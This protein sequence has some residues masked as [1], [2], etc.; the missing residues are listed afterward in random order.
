MYEFTFDPE[1]NKKLIKERNISFEEV[2]CLINENKLIDV[3]D[4]HNKQEYPN[5]K[6]YVIDVEGYIY[7]VPFEKIGDRIYLKTIFPS[8]KYTKQYKMRNKNE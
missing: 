2:I 6:I 5:Q 4:H 8:R 1:K 3:L 7:L